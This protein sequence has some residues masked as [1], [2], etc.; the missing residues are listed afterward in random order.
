MNFEI[1][2]NVQ[3][4]HGSSIP[5]G[6]CDKKELKEEDINVQVRET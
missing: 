2:S 6:T 3:V 5:T 4:E 1:R